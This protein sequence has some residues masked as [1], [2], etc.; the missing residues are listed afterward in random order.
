MELKLV[1]NPPVDGNAVALEVEAEG[2]VVALS[3]LF[4]RLFS[5]YV[6]AGGSMKN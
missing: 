1:L 3:A 2:S 6:D 5:Q 4:K